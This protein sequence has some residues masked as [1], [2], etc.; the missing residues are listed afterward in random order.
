MLEGVRL[1]SIA[2]E[3]GR[4]TPCALPRFVACESSAS[5]L[6]FTV[7]CREAP[8]CTST[9]VRVLCE[10]TCGTPYTLAARMSMEVL[11][12]L[13]MTRRSHRTQGVAPAAQ[14][15]RRAAAAAYMPQQEVVGHAW[16]A[17]TWHTHCHRRTGESAQ[18]MYEQEA[19]RISCIT[20]YAC[21]IVCASVVFGPFS[22]LGVSL[23]LD[24]GRRSA[25]AMGHAHT[26]STTRRLASLPQHA[27]RIGQAATSET[28]SQ[29]SSRR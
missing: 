27:R 9:H 21:G 20:S 25:P 2:C 6:P 15:V 19:G 11:P 17:Y 7:A 14:R 4:T 29:Y 8:R 13:A 24:S 23:A 22:L 16:L 5:V 12:T 28:P 18:D 1:R 10:C 26:A 3:S